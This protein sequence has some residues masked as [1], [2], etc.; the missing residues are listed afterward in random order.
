MIEIASKWHP[1]LAD[2]LTEGRSCFYVGETGKPVSFQFQDHLTGR[3]RDGPGKNISGVVFRRMRKLQGGVIL[4]RGVDATL[5]FDLIDVIEPVA[6]RDQAEAL[7]SRVIDEL[8]TEGH[9][10][11]PEGAGS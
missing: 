6:D 1:A 10:V 8:R 5:R 7:E 2:G 3:T 4:E 11:Y 9:C